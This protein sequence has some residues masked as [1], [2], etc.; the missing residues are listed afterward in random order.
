MNEDAVDGTLFSMKK[1]RIKVPDA[2]AFLASSSAT[3]YG[4]PLGADGTP[5]VISSMIFFLPGG[6]EAK[7]S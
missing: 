2:L 1:G 7:V 4:S 6:L 3:P 5:S